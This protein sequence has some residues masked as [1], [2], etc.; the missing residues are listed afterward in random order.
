LPEAPGISRAHGTLIQRAGRTYMP[1]YHPAAALYNGGLLGTLREDFLRLQ[2]HLQQA[3]T[4]AA[5]P[6]VELAPPSPPDEQ[7]GLF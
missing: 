5:A 2:A 6:L 1:C 3:V 4:V 7:L